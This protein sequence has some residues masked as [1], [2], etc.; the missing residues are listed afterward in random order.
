MLNIKKFKTGIKIEPKGTLQSDAQGEL[1]VDSSSGKLNYHDGSSRSPV[2]TEESTSTLENKTIDADSNTVSNIE[3]DNLKSGV[4]NTST[5]LNA[6]SDTQL[7]SALA[8][9][10]Y[11]DDQVATKDEASEISYNN[12]L[13]GLAAT[14]LQDATDEIDN[15]VDNLVTLSG[16]ALDSV[17][18]GSFTGVTISDN[19]TVKQALQEL[20]TAHETLSTAQ[21]TT[22]GKVTDLI[23]LSGVAANAE[24]LGT[25]TGSIIPDSS[26]VKGAAQ[27]LETNLETHTTSTEAHGATGAVVGTTNTQTLTNKTLTG[28][29]LEGLTLVENYISEES[30]DSS[31]S[32]ASAVIA[33]PT[34]PI[35]RLTNASLV[36][37]TGISALESSTFGGVL[38]VVNATGNDVDILNNVG[39]ASERILTGTDDDITLAPDAA[40][41]LKYDVTS[42]KYRVIGG[43]GSGSV[44][45]KAIAGENL[46]AR[47]AVYLSVGAADSRNAG[48]AYK[49]DSSNDNRIEY[50]GLVKSTVTAGQTA[51]IITGGV[52]KGFTG[53]SVG[54]PVYMNPLTPGAYSQTDPSDNS[55]DNTFVIK[56]GTAISATQVL[57]NADQ[58]ASAYFKPATTS[59]F[60][61][62]NNQSPAANVTNLIFNGA[63]IRSFIVEYS[64]YRITDSNELAQIGRLRGIYK[65]VANEWLMS[66]DYSGENAGVNFTI[67]TTGQIQYT[68]TNVAGTSYVGTLE[69]DI[70]KAFEV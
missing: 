62:A 44:V 57:I 8:V 56:L 23:T 25:F 29:I 41:L 32:G 69:Y 16:V 43:T 40:L 15:N 65:T 14:N 46:S 31:I 28:A 54:V 19:Q 12:T 48:E 70:V 39:V 21:G 22:D 64:I 47:E 17:N 37:V 38:T 53:L 9:K 18:L 55:Y 33:S 52:V 36:S 60:S 59:S 61:I 68:S 27:A 5:T 50:V 13:S 2:V 49:L 35:V 26:T 10:T 30:E 67:T 58:A 3:V 51:K 4:L 20:E 6:A 66:D 7:P 45:I 24:D 1:E 34:K 63:S 11:V 42:D